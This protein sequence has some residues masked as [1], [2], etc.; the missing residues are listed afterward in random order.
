MNAPATSNKANGA[1]QQLH[2]DAYDW[3]NQCVKCGY[4]LPACP[5]YESMGMESASPRG[6]INLVKLAAEGKIDF[7][8][9]LS[10]PIELC[11]GC[12]ACET[13]CPVGVPYGHILEAA[14][15]AIA[16][17]TPKKMKKFKKLAL[18]HL[19]PYPERMT[20]LG[21]GVMLYQ[22]S[23]LSKLVRSSNLLK[24][25]S[26]ALA[27]L[28]QAL[29][30]IESSSKRFKP[31]TV[32]PAKGETR[33]R[34]AFFT[35]CIMDSMM[36]RINRLTIELLTLVGCEVVLPANQSCCG[37]LH[38]HQ[39]EAMQ[40][41]A[42]AKRNIQAFM[43]IDADVIVNNAGGCGASLQEY[44]QLLADDREWAG[45]AMEFSKKSQDISQILHHL[46][47]LPFTEEYRGIVTFQDSCHLRNVQKVQKEPRLLLQ[48]IPGI[49]Y[50]EM[51]GYDRCCGSG[52][53]Y[54]LLHFE[55]SMKIL[56][57]KMN[58]LKKTMATTI[59]TVN[60]GCQMQM[61][62]GIQKDGSANHIK[63]M[64]L[65]EVLAKACGLK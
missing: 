23:G 36:S 65:V 40:A 44:E 15:E 20:L 55:E 33:L 1:V 53:I 16:P 17:Y 50:V 8:K 30:P 18:V 35:G 6:R 7:Q 37:A 28:E 14:K 32:I 43:Q 9:D 4:C 38:S 64:H 3:T 27:H 49:I 61:N 11:L 59:V 45:A 5:T 2:T 13:A 39:G 52:G 54:N 57:G 63:S 47:P 31:G 24:K 21:N 60:P 29:P 46:G 26:P 34:A 51:E 12:R 42:L 22:K 48:S 56:D 25:I 58:D 10:G 19:F 41:K 62:I